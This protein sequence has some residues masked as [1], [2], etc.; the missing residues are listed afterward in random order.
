VG[1]H[2]F[3]LANNF[4][5]RDLHKR[6][7]MMKNK[8]DKRQKWNYTAALPV[9]FLAMVTLS[10]PQLNAEIP[11][12]VTNK[13]VEN[14]KDVL[15]ALEGK[16]DNN[17]KI[18]ERS[19]ITICGF[20]KGKDSFIPGVTIV[21]KGSTVGTITDP[22]GKFVIKTDKGDVLKFVMVGYKTFEYRVEKT[23]DNL[24]V[25]LQPDDVVATRVGKMENFKI[26]A[27]DEQ[28]P[29][30]AVYGLK[31]LTGNP[32]FILD[33]KPIEPMNDIDPDNI[34]SI[35]VLKND[36]ATAIYGERGKDGVILITTKKPENFTIDFKEST[37][38][39]QENVKSLNEMLEK[40]KPLIVID[41][42]KKS[43]DYDLKSINPND[44]ESFT[45]LKDKSA[46]ELYGEDGRNGVIIVTKKSK[47]LE[48][49]SD[50]LELK[51]N[52]DFSLSGDKVE[53]NAGENQTITVS[54][55]PVKSIVK[56]SDKSSLIIR[57]EDGSQPLVVVDGVKKGKL[58][59]FNPGQF[60]VFRA[61]AGNTAKEKYGE[62]GAN[63][64]VEIDTK[65]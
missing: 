18:S 36:S 64:V 10:V 28:Q 22:E 30:I 27:K 17:E 20:V 44:I 51:N 2:K 3:A 25:V 63:G 12:K 7:T 19:K 13:P 21:I 31:A 58:K 9:L 57:N 33:G 41:G 61:Y 60:A 8:S 34:E 46:V 47:L 35:S 32:L 45:I 16:N 6:I 50:V 4:R 52:G 5:Q 43:K 39:V 37:T 48:Y 53:M 15:P 14:N 40:D 56:K 11:E 59:E 62:E 1:E 54:A 42:E 38:K 65:K 49:K 29:K 24:V 23:Q 26:E 55:K